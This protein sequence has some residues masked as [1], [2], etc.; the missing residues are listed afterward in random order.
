MSMFRILHW[1]DSHQNS[2]GANVTNLLRR[3]IPNLNVSVHTGDIVRDLYG[4]DISYIEPE[5]NFITVGNHDKL[6]NYDHIN[7]TGSH[8]ESIA[9]RA[10][11]FNRYFKPYYNQWGVTMD[12]NDTNWY[13]IYEDYAICLISVDVHVYK[14][15]FQ[16]N[17]DFLN[18][19]LTT[20]LN[21]KLSVIMMTHQLNPF[22]NQAVACP[23]TFYPYYFS[24]Y[25]YYPDAT[26][27]N[28]WPYVLKVNDIVDSY[29]KSG[30]KVLLWLHGHEHADGFLTHNNVPTFAVGGTI[31]DKYND[32]A[33]TTG[34]LT[35]DVVANLYEIDIESDTLRAYRL[36]AGNMSNGNRRKLL[37]W[38]YKENKIITSVG[39]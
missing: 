17:T 4:E 3:S 18:S 25:S 10:D 1:S 13:K 38:S 28:T 30:L 23:F 35:S 22:T 8:P 19:I 33:R 16:K 24:N 26:I 2:N 14:T 15:D 12:T 31:I 29:I 20:C 5:N 21:R 37:V 34:G 7:D 11:I 9:S 32:V 39:W 27:P 36:G 6:L